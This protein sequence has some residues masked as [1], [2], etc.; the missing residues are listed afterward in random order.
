MPALFVPRQVNQLWLNPLELENI[1]A[2]KKQPSFMEH[3]LIVF[4]YIYVA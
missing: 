3:H 4:K 1:V 2:L